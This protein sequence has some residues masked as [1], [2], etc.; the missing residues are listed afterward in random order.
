MAGPVARRAS[1]RHLYSQC[2]VAS[3]R[4]FAVCALALAGSG[5]AVSGHLGSLFGSANKTDAQG[6]ASDD[7]TGSTAARRAAP[8]GQAAPPE[9]DLVF[10]RMAIVDLLR[11]GSKDMSAP[12]ENPSSGARGTVTPI[13][14][15]YKRDGATCHDFLASYLRPGSE[16]WLQ[17]EACRAQHGKWEVK[18]LKPWTR[19]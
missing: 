12:W 2:A 13:A 15:A 4:L 17:G 8:M 10:T 19:S 1:R 9:A 11:R 16:T 6:Y 18:T 7:A 5:C 14:S 3:L